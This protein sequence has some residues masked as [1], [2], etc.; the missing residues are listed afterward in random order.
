MSVKDSINDLVQQIGELQNTVKEHADDRATVDIDKLGEELLVMRSS[1]DDL[2]AA[3]TKRQEERIIRQ[4]DPIGVEADPHAVLAAVASG[5]VELAK[6]L[7]SR[8]SFE[9]RVTHGKFAG[10]KY[11]DLAFT[12]NLLDRISAFD[13]KGKIKPPSAE[14]TKLLDATTAGAGDEFVPTGMAAELWADSF[15]QS[16]V[17]GALGIVPMPTDPFDFP[18]GWGS[19]TWRKG[20]VG[21]ATASQDPAT[22]KSTFTATEQIAEV[23][24]AYDLD[25]DAVIATLP[26]LRMDLTRSAAEQMDAFAINADATSAATGNI[27]LDDD[28]PATDAYYLSAGQD[29]IRHYFLVDRTGQSAN[30]STTL[31]DALWR[32]GVAKAGKYA[33][34]PEKVLV[35]TNVKT[36]LVSLMG[37]SQVRTL[38]TYGPQATI[39]TGE[40]AKIDGKPVIVSESMLLAEDDGKISATAANND[41]GT[42]AIVNRDMWKVGFR[43]QLLIEIERDI[44]KRIYVMVVSFRMAIAAQDNGDS[45][46]RGKDHTAGIHGITYA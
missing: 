26:S 15:L 22:A 3:E 8:P 28:T 12:R 42:I 6:Y 32:A 24:W 18:A 4:G 9:G 20:G 17:V 27:N 40:L 16:K 11:S 5:D 1:I 7:Q 41:E 39:L 23:N 44:R 36:Y 34:D 13:Q 25:E 14:L 35:V 33:I 30:I 2:Q 21:E 29:G 37:L 43:R 45:T 38:D 19:I 46:T 31:T 10:Q